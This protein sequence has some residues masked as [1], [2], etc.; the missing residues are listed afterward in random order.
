MD[1]SVCTASMSS[2]TYALKAQRALS[3]MSI[4]CRV[5]RLDGAK[6]KHGCAYGIE[7][8]CGQLENVKRVLQSARIKPRHLYRGDV[9]I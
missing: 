9:E 8:S 2:Q 6:S 4:P 3:E 5:V 7:F 1:I